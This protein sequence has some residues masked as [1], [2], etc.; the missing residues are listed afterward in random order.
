M[1]VT[2]NAADDFLIAANP[3][4]VW[5]YLAGGSVMSKSGTGG[6]ID[7]P[8][9]SW[10]WNG[11]Q[12]L[13]SANVS[14]V[15]GS[16][17]TWGS[18]EFEPGYLHMDP[19]DQSSV[20]VRFTAPA[21]GTYVISG[22]FDAEDAYEA[23]HPVQILDN[24][25]VI[26]SGTISGPGDSVPFDLTETLNEGDTIDF[27]VDTGSGGSF[28]GT[29]LAATITT[30]P[31][32]WAAPVSGNF[33][34]AANWNPASVPTQTDD[35]EI[36]PVGTYTV[37]SSVSETVNSFTTEAGATLDITGGAFAI[38]NGT[39][40]GTNAG[41]ILVGTGATL[42]LAG[43]F[44]NS[45]T[46]AVSGGIV[47]DSATI[48][49]SGSIVLDGGL[50][51]LE[52]GA[53]LGPGA[54]T[55]APDYASALQVDGTSMPTNTI[56]GF[57]PGDSIDLAAV[58]FS[59]NS[60]IQLLSGDVLQI[61]ED[62][63][64]YS[65]NLDAQD[66]VGQT[67]QLSSDGNVGTEII[68]VSES[69]TEPTTAQFYNASQAVYLD[70][71]TAPP[72]NTALTLLPV[73]TQAA[74][75]NDGF[76]G[77]AFEDANGNIIV[78]FEGTVKGATAYDRGS[79]IAD[80]YLYE[81]KIP[82]AF[83]DALSFLNSVVQYD[84]ETLGSLPIFLSGHSLGAA[85]AEDVSYQ[86]DGRYGGVTFATPGDPR[87]P[88]AVSSSN[89]VDYVDV[90][91]PIANWGSHYGKVDFIGPGRLTELTRQ[92]LKEL[93]D[94]DVSLLTKYLDFRG[95]LNNH[96][97]THYAADLGLRL[98]SQQ[99]VDITSQSANTA[100]L[101]NYAAA[102]P[103]NAAAAGP[104][105]SALS[106][107]QLLSRFHHDLRLI[108]EDEADSRF[109]HEIHKD[110]KFIDD[111]NSSAPIALKILGGMEGLT[112]SGSPANQLIH[113]A[114]DLANKLEDHYHY[115]PKSGGETF[116]ILSGVAD[117]FPIGGSHT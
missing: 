52:N 31:S 90:G 41:A 2:Y 1:T 61:T 83:N 30:L 76:F 106:E 51:E 21:A 34:T 96:E 103:S 86:T 56:A 59:R 36:S 10:W 97:L 101:T 72:A 26:L 87:L 108:L 73:A 7:P 80:L 91:D 24:G 28:L 46:L 107:D 47:L 50:F 40:A 69:S 29:G 49:G 93:N 8:G 82:K 70:N 17:L 63:S 67:F 100:L 45:G 84:Q 58:S 62:G 78:A 114:L 33:A 22:N 64:A 42:S 11:A 85:E 48:T 111:P 71:R 43:N 39:G 35:A 89:L 4:G 44:N 102:N 75:L 53:T 117:H 13:Y 79:L 99:Y 109:A 74:W 55:F 18:V 6:K 94:G 14:A 65:L 25:S 19:E 23:G 66:L 92:Q 16:D 88:S 20:V 98:D 3:N 110:V 54:I 95:H 115:W 9:V 116:S 77:Q 113:D 60:S 37:T 32:V 5:T 15:T 104:N 57:S 27:A 112:H 38:N 105:L 12:P 81:G 68:S